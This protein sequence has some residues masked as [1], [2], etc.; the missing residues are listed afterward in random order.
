MDH[1]STQ[2]V[3]EPCHFFFFFAEGLFLNQA[4]KHCPARELE[5]RTCFE[6]VFRDRRL[7]EKVEH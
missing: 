6:A 1:S 5:E 7:L 3:L 4:N 2:S